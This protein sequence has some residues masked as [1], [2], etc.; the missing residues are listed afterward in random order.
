[1]TR[2]KK[3]KKRVPRNGAALAAKSRKSAG[4][5]KHRLEPKGGSKDNVDEYLKDY[6]VEVDPN[7]FLFDCTGC[8]NEFHINELDK[9][10]MCK[11]CYEDDE[12]EF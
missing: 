4:P 9:N 6:G 2:T 7:T 12:C 5:M 10:R 11:S 3:Q 1:M 8:G